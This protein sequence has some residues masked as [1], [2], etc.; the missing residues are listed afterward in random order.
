[1]SLP[2]GETP[3]SMLAYFSRLD[4]FLHSRLDTSDAPSSSQILYGRH[5][6]SKCFGA[7]KSVGDVK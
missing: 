4:R 2:F 6:R 7:L 1:M 5:D 3:I